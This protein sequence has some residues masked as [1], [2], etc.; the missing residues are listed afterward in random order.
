MRASRSILWLALLA[1]APALA[2]QDLSKISDD[3][4]VAPG[5]KYGGLSTVSGDIHVGSNAGA[6]SVQSVSGDVTVDRG[7]KVGDI[8]T[9]SGDL[10]LADDVE[11]GELKNVSGRITLGRGAV[12]DGGVDTVSGSIFADRGSRIEGDI[13]TIS[14]AVGL[15]QAEVAG[16]I[17]FVSSDIT[18]GIGSHVKGRIHLKKPFHSNVRRPP[19]VVIGP[20][21][22]VDGP[23][24][25]EMPVKLYVHGS[26]KTGPIMG[27][28]AIA[29]STPTPPKD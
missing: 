11:T 21:A 13:T 23:L 22:V 14:G 9:T 8:A 17:T 10:K 16:D 2:Q 27:A 5:Q 26:A 20:N 4:Q 29:F 15:V 7:A 28:S 18:V 19:R 25:F 1:A 6:R 12:V 3:V 24:E